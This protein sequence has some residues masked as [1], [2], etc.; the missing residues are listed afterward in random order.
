MGYRDCAT[1][2]LKVFKTQWSRALSNLT[3]YLTPLEKEFGLETS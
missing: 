3:P 1:S 2:I